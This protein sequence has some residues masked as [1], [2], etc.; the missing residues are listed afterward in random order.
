MSNREA[1]EDEVDLPQDAPGDYCLQTPDKDGLRY[2]RALVAVGCKEP[3][4]HSH[5]Q[6]PFVVR[7]AGSRRSPR[8]RTHCTRDSA[9]ETPWPFVGHQRSEISSFSS[10]SLPTQSVR[11]KPVYPVKDD[12]RQ[13]HDGEFDIYDLYNACDG[14]VGPDGFLD[15]DQLKEYAPE[16]AEELN[17]PRLVEIWHHT[18]TGC[19][20]CA[21]I[22]KTLNAVRGTLSEDE[23]EDESFDEEAEALDT[24]AINS[25]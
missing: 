8:R 2:S 17:V 12:K 24:D 1:C 25:N 5:E 10:P 19:P 4:R 3:R 9:S 21:R 18:K 7:L 14:V 15:V 22:V 13:F 6:T 20:E 11:R 16:E 23:E